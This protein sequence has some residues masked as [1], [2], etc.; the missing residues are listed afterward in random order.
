MGK[1][2]YHFMR[3][4]T[5]RLVYGGKTFLLDPT[6]S[7]KGALPSF[8]GIAPNPMV[9]LP[10]AAEEI[11]KDIDIVIVSHL[12][13]DHFDG[14][15]AE[16]L[17]KNVPMLTPRNSAP[18]NPREPAVVAAFKTRLDEMGFTDVREIGSETADHIAVDGI[19]LHQVFARH[20]KGEVGDRMGGVNGLVF[21]ADGQPTIYWAGDT[22]LDEGGEVA[23]VLE[24]FRPDIVIAHTGGPVVEVLS[25]EILLMDA[26]QG[27]AFFEL[28]ETAKPGVEI[29]AI[30]MDA[31]DHCFSTRADLA[32]EIASLDEAL[33]QRIHIPA[34]G[35]KLVFG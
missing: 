31:L 19:T 5:A 22:I 35:D 16:L 33:R 26:A 10:M 21:Q 3:N 30:H 12:H 2:E 9:D 15:A 4:A 13:G 23:A 28:A 14:A 7:M 1:V 27:R 8:A 18:V 32:A 11:V 24:R 34:D 6:L 20:G 25:P 17:D 29:V